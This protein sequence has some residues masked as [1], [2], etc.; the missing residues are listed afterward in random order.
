MLTVKVVKEGGSEDIFCGERVSYNAVRHAIEILGTECRICIQ[1][2]QVAYVMN[3]DG[4]TIS[5]YDGVMVEPKGSAV[6]FD[7]EGSSHPM[8]RRL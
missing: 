1:P 7:A 4:K 5:K 8:T 6:I 2:G 3:S